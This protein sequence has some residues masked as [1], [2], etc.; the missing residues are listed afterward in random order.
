[1]YIA[2]NTTIHML[3]N[4][5][6]KKDYNETLWF[7]SEANQAS[8][9]LGKSVGTF[10][11]QSYQRVERD[12]CRIEAKYLAVYKCNYMMFVNASHE[13]KYFYA[14]VDNVTYINE[15]VVEVAY[16]IDVMQT[17][18]FDIVTK[19][20]FV[21]REHA[22]TDNVGDNLIPENIELGE[23]VSSLL[24]RSGHMTD[25]GYVAL[26][27]VDSEGADATGYEYGGIYSG[28]KQI[29]WTETEMRNGEIS[30]WIST[31][32][33]QG[34]GTDFLRALFMMPL[35]F[36]PSQ[37]LDPETADGNTNA[38]SYDITVNK[39]TTI[40]GD[41]QPKNNKL[42]TYP[43]NFL[44]VYSTDGNSAVYPFEYFG[45]NDCRFKMKGNYNPDAEV[46]LY[47]V[48]YKGIAE[49]VDE[50]LRMKVS[51]QCGWACDSFE[52]WL[53][54]VMSNPLN[55]VGEATHGQ[56]SVVGGMIGGP[57]GAAVGAIANVVG[58]AITA[59]IKPP[60]AGGNSEGNVLISSRQKDFYF[61]CKHVTP[62]FARIIDDYFQMY[63]YATHR[64]KTP[65]LHVRQRWTYTKTVNC[66]FD[67]NIPV[68]AME[69]IRNIFN[70][71]IAIWSDLSNVGNYTLDN[72]ILGA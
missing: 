6:L 20:C 17:W 66:D 57:Q 13:N 9:F 2:P 49:N 45:T 16:T 31:I 54:Y 4:V 25:Y 7:A 43:Y 1:M 40:I 11:T 53:G 55:I 28:L 22:S 52:A 18:W 24:A 19:P 36:I 48:Q 60:Q 12:Y 62:Y 63:G 72:P 32:V 64:I 21:E 35:D 3:M 68:D 70:S 37:A 27:T 56:G 39:S 71:G 10:L 8:Y 61:T 47:P 38:V 33:R 15:N 44:Y 41:Y 5:P 65:N 51:I 50:Q 29:A 34:K 14:F 26:S 23:Y 69:K 46:T 42:F 67:G 30:T 58:S 59:A